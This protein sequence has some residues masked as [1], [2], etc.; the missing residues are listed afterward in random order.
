MTTTDDNREATAG[1][2]HSPLA[3]HLAPL[4]YFAIFA[5]LIVLTLLTVGLSFL[6]LGPWHLAVGAGIG[7][8]KALLV[9]LFFMHVISSH[10][11]TWI[12]IGAGLLWTAI[13]IAGTL[14]DYLTRPWLAY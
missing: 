12:V 5:A 3:L 8:V 13:L 14:S 10:R 4:T 9:V 11:F 1:G 6:D 7:A 2:V